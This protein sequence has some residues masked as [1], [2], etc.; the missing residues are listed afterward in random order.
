MTFR[1]LPLIFLRQAGD[2]KAKRGPALWNRGE[3]P[4]VSSA[5]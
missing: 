4:V 2:K 3:A 1:I 5:K